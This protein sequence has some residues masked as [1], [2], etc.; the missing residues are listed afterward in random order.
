MCKVI[1]VSI[2][3]FMLVTAPLGGL[4]AACAMRCARRAPVDVK[5]PLLSALGSPLSSRLRSTLGSALLSRLC[6]RRL[7][8]HRSVPALSSLG[9]ARLSHCSRPIP[10]LHCCRSRPLE[11]LP[12]PPTSSSDVGGEGGA[13]PR[14]RQL[15][16][17]AGARTTNLQGLLQGFTLV[18]VY[19][20]C[21]RALQGLLQE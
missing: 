12:R 11:R 1:E 10:P 19:K 4:A 15:A 9:S 8:S 2:H 16:A 13:T 17:S 7:L 20:A 6:A 21:N 18:M 3:T 14:P 5:F